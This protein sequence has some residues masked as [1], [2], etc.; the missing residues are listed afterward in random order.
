MS[1]KGIMSIAGMSGLYKLVAQTKAGFVVE[2]MTDK[3]RYPINASQKISMLDDISV[4]TK[5]G[6][7]PLKEILLKMKEHDQESSNVDPKGS[8]ES[9]KK[10]FKTVVPDFDEDRVYASDIKKMITWYQLVKDIV[11]VEEEK[12]EKEEA[13]ET[14]LTAAAGRE[15]PVHA[16][17]DHQKVKAPDKKVASVKTRKKV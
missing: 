5:G 2:S 14:A 10:F 17:T 3:K 6:D 1:L 15:H 16:V 4:F 13:A 12:D 11:T 8:P 9:L 7:L